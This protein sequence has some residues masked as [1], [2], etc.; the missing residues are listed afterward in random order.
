MYGRSAE[1][2]TRLAQRL[3]LMLERRSTL[4]THLEVKD[5]PLGRGDPVATEFIVIAVALIAF[6]GY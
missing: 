6:P 2:C 4:K 5:K 3:E 1:L